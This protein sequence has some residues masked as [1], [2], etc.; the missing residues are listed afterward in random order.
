[1]AKADDKLEQLK[2][3]LTNINKL[4]QS[5]VEH[6]KEMI[7]NYD[8]LTQNQLQG[9]ENQDII[10][11]NQ[12][13]IIKNQTIITQNQSSIIH[14]QSVIV[15]NQAYLKTL[16]HTQTEVLALLTKRSKNEISEEVNN[17]LIKAQEEITQGFENPL[18]K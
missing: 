11:N 4:M 7:D 12:K 2:E 17:F 6:Q 15:K 3:E 18:T 5:F 1:M 16:I 9:T 13:I 14:N 10:I 8:I